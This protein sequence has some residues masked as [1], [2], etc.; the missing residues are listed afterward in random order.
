MKQAGLLHRTLVSH[1]AGWYHVGE[2]QGGNYR[3][4]TYL[5]REFLP[6]LKWSQS[7]VNQLLV[8]NPR[9]VCSPTA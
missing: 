6:R 9:E 7:D 3:G 1:D 4:Y 2:P 5:F 8:G